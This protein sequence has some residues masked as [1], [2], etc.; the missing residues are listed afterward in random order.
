MEIKN[1][2]TENMTNEEINS[3]IK[4]FKQL[5]QSK[6][7]NPGGGA[8][9][10]VISIRTLSSD[11]VA[12]DKNGKYYELLKIPLMDYL[13]AMGYYTLFFQKNNTDLVKT[14]SWP[15]SYYASDYDWKI[16]NGFKDPF[17]VPVLSPKTNVHIDRF[18]ETF[19]YGYIN[20][21]IINYDEK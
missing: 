5:R 8:R 17:Y 2:N 14:M 21:F 12:F 3:L 15:S 9:S 7:Q 18:Y 6:T 16:E 19:H 10:K 1:V 11:D 20:I 13:N 4:Q